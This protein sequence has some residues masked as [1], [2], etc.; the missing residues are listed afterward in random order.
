MRRRQSMRGDITPVCFH[1]IMLVLLALACC[2][3]SHGKQSDTNVEATV[4]V[5]TPADKS[6]FHIYLLMGQ[7][8]MAGRGAL[9][10]AAQVNDPRILALDTNNQW[11]VARDP[12]HQKV[13]R[14]EPGVGP[15]MSFAREMAKADTN[16]VIGLVPCA[17]GGT[18]L[19]RWVKG[20]DL[21]ERAVSRAKVAAQTGV[22]C[23]VLWHQ[24]EA[25]SDKKEFA[26]TYET[27]LTKMFKDLRADLGEPDLPVVVGQLGDF[28]PK[29][30][31]PYADTVRAAIK[32]VSAKLPRAGLADSAGL[33][34]KGD[35]LHFN[36]ASQIEFGARYA[37]AML[38]LQKN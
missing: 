2:S 16:S 26:E 15:G 27:R 1:R 20:G 30:K 5:L 36:T 35:R 13:G 9:D 37:R 34:D 19:K 38:E 14:I 22:I 23:G 21:Y 33:T 10:S 28:L 29:E 24:G 25:D 31:H 18:P 11:V 12:L 3:V 7:S 4:T 17:V 32:N 6:I 8:N